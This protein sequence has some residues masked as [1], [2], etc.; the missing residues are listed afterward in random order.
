MRELDFGSLAQQFASVAGLIQLGTLFAAFTLAWFT[1]SRLRSRV[2]EQLQPGFTKIS[3][4]SVHRLALP[5]AFLIFAY[6]GLATLRRLGHAADLLTIAFYLITAFAV[7]RLV[8]Y[9]LR[10]AIPPSPALKASERV[11]VLGIWVLFA[12][13]VTGLGADISSALHS[14]TFSVGARKLSLGLLLEALVTVAL[15][16][17]FAMALS[18]L[19]EKKLMSVD[20]LD[21][22]S[23]VVIGKF[24]RAL[25]LALSVLIA[26]PLVGVDLT[27]L[28]VFGG[29]LGVGLGFGLQK[30]ASSYVSGFIILLDRSIQLGD[31]VTI[32]NRQ[33]VVDAIKARYTVI[34]GLDG[35]EAIVPNDTIIT[36]TV[37]NHSY[38]NKTMAVKTPFTIGYD[39]NVE[40]VQKLV[41]DLASAHPR[42][43]SVPAPNVVVR[44]LGDNGIDMELSVWINDAD[45]G[46]GA[47]RSDLLIAMWHAFKANEISVPFPQREVRMAGGAHPPPAAPEAP[48]A[49]F[50]K[51]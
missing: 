41:T 39:S 27:L 6:L 46:Q 23:R 10:H 40:A 8:V 7:I 26:L 13:H 48:A 16:V 45:Q 28:S 49:P 31:L 21:I 12:L 2:P 32:D 43:L 14:I 4:G 50:A 19:I 11:I 3:A 5:I 25:L 1:A 44:A 34:R 20:S 29:A 36:N 24:A 33:G 15:A 22:S 42:V 18:G 51:G 9:L 17:F 38:T 47:L 35:T 30:I 37:I